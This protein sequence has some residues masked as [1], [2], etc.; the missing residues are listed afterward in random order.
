MSTAS[1]KTTEA[2]P[3]LYVMDISYF[4]GKIE[5][6]LRY[7]ELP[8]QRVCVD[9]R[10]L[11]GLVGRQTGVAQVP[12]MRLPDGTWLR[13]STAMLRFLEARHPE[14]RVVPADPAQ[15]FLE[16]LVEDYCDEWLWRPAMWWRWVPE[17]SR[18][19]VG[20]RIAAEVLGSIPLPTE[21]K[22]RAFAL[23]QHHAWLE[24]DGMGPETA[25]AVRDLYLDE[26]RS[27]ETIL[28]GRPFLGGPSPSVLD[29]GYFGPMFRHFACDPDPA[30]VMRETAP[31]V[32]AW[33]G[34]LWAARASRSLAPA[35]HAPPVGPGFDA[36]FE[37]VC[38]VYL[39]YV[40]ENAR[41]LRAGVRRFDF[42]AGPFRFRG[43]RTNAHRAA[44]R[45]ALRAAHASLDAN[46]REAV[47]LRLAPHGGLGALL[48]EDLRCAAEPPALVLPLAPKPRLSLREVA[49]LLLGDTFG[50][51]RG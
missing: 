48:D 18:L 43:L 41:A 37:R 8:Y 1:T 33:V 4:S 44:C 10:E 32:Y 11:V 6:Y 15:A 35:V 45:T 49:E 39:P 34:R 3:T 17:T 24:G 2:L 28:G 47:R 27:L 13:E 21:L 12:A 23:R 31:E 29:Y 5:A 22:A 14:P 16:A 38:R 20:R 26:L 30:I 42:A 46:A 9:H 36:I 25:D 19:H 51:Q 7:K 50:T 40:R